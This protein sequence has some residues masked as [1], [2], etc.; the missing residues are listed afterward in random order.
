MGKSVLTCVEE[1]SSGFKVLVHIAALLDIVIA[2]YRPNAAASEIPDRDFPL[3]EEVVAKCGATELHQGLLNTLELFYHAVGILS[4]RYRTG[5]APVRNSRRDASALQILSI[6][7]GSV[8][9]PIWLLFVPYAVSLSL[10]TACRE[11][12]HSSVETRRSRAMLRIKKC[13]EHLF[14][15]GE[16][17]WSATFMA[18]M[19]SKILHEAK[20]SHSHSLPNTAAA[21]WN[22]VR[23]QPASPDS[24]GTF[25]LNHPGWNLNDVEGLL[26]SNLDPSLPSFLQDLDFEPMI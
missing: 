13:C 5:E 16:I 22:S 10:G 3:F 24:E 1:S 19:G 25:D 23:L 26:E 9:Q 6:M 7:D 11:L 15:L 17:F 21:T 2:L 4:C 8:M 14:A 18:E 12:R 20:Q